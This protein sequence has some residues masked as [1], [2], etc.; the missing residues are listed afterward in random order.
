M[1]R[2]GW[3]RRLLLLSLMLAGILFVAL[4]IALGSAAAQTRRV[5]LLHSF[6]P[7]FVPWT[8]FSGQFR[9]ELIRQS[10]NAIDLYEASL[11]SAR[12]VQ[13]E[14]QGPLVD[15][16]HSLFATRK[17][18]L[19]VTMGAPAA[20]FVQQFRAQFFPSTALV[21]GAQEQRVIRKDA[22]TA[23]DAVVSVTLDFSKWI[24][25]ILQVLPDTSHIAWAVGASPLERTWTEEF[26]R[27]SQPFANRVTFEW[28]NDLSFEDML[29]RAATLPPNSA[30]FYVDLRMD[31]AGVP[32]D[33]E[34]VLERLRE[35]TNAPIFSYV[36]SYLGR[37]IVG[38]PLLSSQEVGRRMA[39]VAV[40]ILS[41]ETAGK[42][43]TP[44]VGV[45][46]Q[47]TIGE[48]Y[49]VGILV[50]L[51]FRPIALCGFASRRLGNVTGG[52][53]LPCSSYC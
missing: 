4:V 48:S 45:G 14:D 19:I 39:N 29:N 23:N 37:G 24:E 46:R 49:S 8:F 34:H 17:L 2:S 52:N 1:G 15:Y 10:P 22:L 28:F 53:L 30:I 33:H 21:I 16:L 13:V 40:R 42:I 9:E 26:R 41:G 18:D 7:N 43:E 38:G 35:S 32:L 47:H 12:F 27:A 5:L 50:K 25:N 6:G 31:G 20:R 44:P 3:V 51:A 11:E 36:D